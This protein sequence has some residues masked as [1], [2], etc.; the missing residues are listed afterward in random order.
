MKP[1]IKLDESKTPDGVSMALYEHDG[2]Y[3]ISLRGQELMH[4]KAAAS[5]LRLGELGVEHLGEA[6][7][8][9]I[10]IGGLG[11]GFTL[12]SVL[13]GV[14][15]DAK[16]EVVELLEQVVTWNRE[17][18]QDLNGGL[19]DDPR[20]SVRVADAVPLLRKSHPNTY[21]A[22]LLDVDNGP[23]GMVKV[24]NNSLYS[25]KGMRQVR[26]ALKPGGRVVV[27]S[28]GED[29]H[30]K[31]SLKRAGYRVGVVPAKVHERAKR[32]AYILYVGD[33]D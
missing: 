32:A 17:R 24:S 22:I 11:L 29:P 25:Q 13:A 18:L 2:A 21:D 14:G 28:A 30:F 1:R 19:L 16:V 7:A 12:K 27:W 20:V 6:K 26:S 23:T 4:S 8:P 9:R 5:E 3:S 10:L 33:R 15:P 31:E